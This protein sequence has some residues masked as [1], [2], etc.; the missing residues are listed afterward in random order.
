MTYNLV[1]ILIYTLLFSTNRSTIPANSFYDKEVVHYFGETAFYKNA[2]LSRWEKPI[3][4]QCTGN[5]SSVDY[6]KVLQLIDELRPELGN[7]PIQLVKSN[8]N[9]VIHF[10]DNL[11][12]FERNI[13]FK[14]EKVP[15][16]FMRPTL[17]KRHEFLRADL[18]IHPSLINE[19]KHE[20]L[21]HEFCHGLGL[22]SHS[23]RIFSSENLLGKRIFE[24]EKAF[25]KSLHA[26]KMPVLDRMAIQFLYN[27]VLS[28]N[29]SKKDFELDYLKN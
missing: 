16:G 28:L 27:R 13:A 6:E 11:S 25:E 14:N 7:I 22:M 12:N 24:N 9:F 18:Y 19:K 1:A 26:Q 5:Y 23:Y 20:V 2:W 15:F 17:N 8:G 3:L 29:Y 4:V 21:R 10:E